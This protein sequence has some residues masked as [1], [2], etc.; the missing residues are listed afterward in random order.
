MGWEYRV[1]KEIQ[2][3]KYRHY[4][5]KIVY[6]I[7]EV[8]VDDNGDVTHIPSTIP[9]CLS[10]SVDEL[11]TEIQNMLLACDKPVIDYNTGEVVN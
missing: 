1:S 4:D 3:H 10:E 7:K 2:T 8:F 9:L 5:P 11:K 6:G